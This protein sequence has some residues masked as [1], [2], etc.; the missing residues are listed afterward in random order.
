M[1]RIEQEC[2]GL[3][4]PEGPA[5]PSYN[6]VQ[7]LILRM[8]G[9]LLQLVAPVE[10]HAAPR[11]PTEPLGARARYLTTEARLFLDEIPDAHVLLGCTT[12]RGAARRAVRSR[13]GG[14]PAR[15]R[16]ADDAPVNACA[17]PSGEPRVRGPPPA[18]P[19]VACCGDDDRLRRRGP[20]PY[21]PPAPDGRHHRRPRP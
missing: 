1:D 15:V 2:R 5:D 11:P 3:V 16:S 9:Y 12:M 21:R 18:S 19:P 14:L 20:Q 6:D 7:T 4:D 17:T 13:P 10:E 8:R